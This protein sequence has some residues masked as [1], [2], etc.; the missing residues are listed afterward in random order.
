MRHIVRGIWFLTL[1]YFI[2]YLLTPALRG[3][4]DAS[5]VLSFV[6]ALF[7]LILVGGGFLWLVLSIHRFFT[8]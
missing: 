5:Q 2:V 3:A 4:V 1:I 7:G 8:R 6:H